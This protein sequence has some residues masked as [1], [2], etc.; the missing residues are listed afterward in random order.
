MSVSIRYFGY[1]GLL[2]NEE[3]KHVEHAL[4][5]GKFQEHTYAVSLLSKYI[6][7]VRSESEN[8]IANCNKGYE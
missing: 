7:Y 3:V 5:V 4:T 8:F 6:K 2:S 1:R